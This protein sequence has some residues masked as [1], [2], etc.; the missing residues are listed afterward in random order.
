M[1]RIGKGSW[2]KGEQPGEHASG[3]EIKT[4]WGS[5]ANEGSQSESI[6]GSGDP[7]CH[8]SANDNSPS[9]LLH[10]GAE[11]NWQRCLPSNWRDAFRESSH[12]SQYLG[13]RWGCSGNC[14]TSSPRPHSRWQTSTTSHRSAYIRSNETYVQ[15]TNF[16]VSRE[17][18]LSTKLFN[19]QQ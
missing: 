16:K 19:S 7:V 11:G 4:D 1:L 9:H 6:K 18:D 10:R 14:S 2:R 17:I 5:E 13:W 12:S 8:P 3:P 15:F